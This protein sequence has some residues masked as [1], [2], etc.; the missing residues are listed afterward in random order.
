[1]P[2]GL[3]ESGG[4]VRYH[5]A[6]MADRPDHDLATELERSQNLDPEEGRDEQ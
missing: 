1:M 4:T 6:E 2:Q 3:S 5:R